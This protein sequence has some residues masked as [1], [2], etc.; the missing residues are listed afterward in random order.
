M[1]RV[2][3]G[4]FS[5]GSERGYENEKPVHKVT[6]PAF[7]IGKYLV[8]QAQWQAVMGNNPSHFKGC[9]NCPV[10]KVTWDDT[11]EFIEKLNKLTGKKFRLPSEAEWEFAARGGNKSRGFEF[12]GSNDVG[13][14]AWY[15]I[16]SSKKTHPVGE[17]K[18]NELGLYDMSGNVWEWCEDDW[19]S[20]YE[21]A[22]DDGM[23]WMDQPRTN[24]RLV[25]GNSWYDFNDFSYRVVHRLLIIA[26]L[27]NYYI[28][29]R[30]AL[31]QF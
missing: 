27:R 10:E 1:V 7:Q 26:T 31:P 29:L 20:S 13:E 28:G 21:N 5:M 17:K 24:N 15:L 3:G 12:S 6:V 19:H 25:R 8:T 14:V 11:K 30:L 16:N 9:E 23:A 2:E 4:T 22:P 18:A